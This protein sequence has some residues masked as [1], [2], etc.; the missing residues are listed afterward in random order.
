MHERIV[1]KAVRHLKLFGV[2]LT[3]ACAAHPCLKFAFNSGGQQLKNPGLCG[4][5][6]ERQ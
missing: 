1:A 4:E 2:I 3:R 6:H 5:L